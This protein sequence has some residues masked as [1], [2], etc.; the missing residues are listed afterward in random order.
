MRPE[1]LDLSL[2]RPFDYARR[3]A[4][5]SGSTPTRRRIPSKPRSVRLPGAMASWRSTGTRRSRRGRSARRW[6]GAGTSRRS[7]SCSATARTR[8]S[9]S[10]SPRSAAAARARRA[11]RCST[12]RRPSA[13]TRR[14]RSRTARCRCR[15][16]S[17]IAFQLDEPALA[18]AIRRERPALAFFASPNN[19]T[20]NRFDAAVMERLARAMEAVCVVDEAYGDF[21]GETQLGAW[22]GAGPVRHAL[23]LQDRARRASPGALVGPGEAIAELDK[24]RLPYN[25]NA[26]SMALACAALEDRARLDARIA[27]VAERRRE[28][29]AACARC[30]A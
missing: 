18:E 13:S 28:L 11:R 15:S 23:A 19:P 30:R 4:S 24:V 7:S 12:R 26:I 27:R 29:D 17:T 22:G 10:S 8:L 1:V 3:G 16:R 25:V 20:G 6:R 21:G 9:P 2:Y 5:W 14:S